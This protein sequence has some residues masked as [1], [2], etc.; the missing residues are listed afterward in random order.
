MSPD[1]ISLMLNMDMIGRMT[2]GNLSILGAG[3]GEGLTDLLRP[4][5]E[6]SGL[7]VALN[8]G[9]SGRSDDANFHRIRVPAV[10]F[11][12][13]MRP[14]YHSPEDLAY[15]V[16]PAG[17][18][19]VLELMHDIV[20]DGASRPQRLAY[21][22]TSRRTAAG[23][24]SGRRYGP[25]RLGITPSMDESRETGVLVDAVAEGASAEAAGIQAG[26]VILMWGEDPLDDI[27]ALFEN[28]QEH[29]PGDVVNLTIERDG[30]RVVI[31]VTLKAAK[32]E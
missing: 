8:E 31:P 28:L 2:G 21:R 27:R 30:K 3:T 5:I 13:G 22:E 1:S 4:H 20:L 7:T 12:T 16:N 26:D 19:S 23:D 15:T 6:A 14:E 25:V 32:P 11:F 17:A 9:G 24:D 18:T 10:H 29:K